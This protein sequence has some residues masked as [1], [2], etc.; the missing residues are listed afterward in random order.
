MVVDRERR[1][2]RRQPGARR[3]EPSLGAGNEEARA[4]ERFGDNFAPV[5]QRHDAH[6]RV[7]NSAQLSR[8]VGAALLE[9][10]GGDE[11]GKR[12][13]DVIGVEVAQRADRL[14][15]AH[16]GEPGGQPLHQPAEAA[17]D[18]EEH[19][20]VS[21][22]GPRSQP[23]Q[24]AAAAVGGVGEVGR[25]RPQAETVGAPG[26]D[27]AE[28][29]IGQPL[30]HLPAEAPA[31]DVV[32]RGVARTGASGQDEVEPG[33][34]DAP[35]RQQARPGQRADPGGHAE[36]E[37]VG[38]RTQA[39]A[40]PHVRP[41]GGRRH[42]L[43][44]Q[45]DSPAQVD[46]PRDTREEAVG[47][48]LDRQPAERAGEHLAAQAVARLVQGDVGAGLGQRVS[49]GQAGDAPA[50]DGNARHPCP[51]TTSASVR[52]RAGSSSRDLVRAKGRPESRATAAA[53]T[54][55]S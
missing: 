13:H 38:Q 16:V 14:A 29:R 51:R 15:E 32:D 2:L 40:R 7:L 47:A 30:D 25:H 18:R 37:P 22:A 55:R 6:R 12:E 50:D 36:H 43:A 28:Q 48:L 26:V 4:V 46:R 24:Q 49:G 27:P 34:G 33:A 23:Q 17:A 5:R 20:P 41:A 21:R 3:D 39:T 8:G 35:R 53:S 11:R 45:P 52:H 31:D 44:A 9:Q 54:S 10:G 1:P 19:G 42:Q